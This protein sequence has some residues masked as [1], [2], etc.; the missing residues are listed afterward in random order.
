ME[1]CHHRAFPILRADESEASDGS[2]KL[3]AEGQDL[4]SGGADI[5]EAGENGDISIWNLAHIDQ[6]LAELGLGFPTEL[7]ETEPVEN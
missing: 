1:L 3:G 4:L 7:P 5:F 2:L 6:E